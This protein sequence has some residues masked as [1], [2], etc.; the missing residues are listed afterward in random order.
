MLSSMSSVPPGASPE[1]DTG[2]FLRKINDPVA[3]DAK[4]PCADL[5]NGLHQAVG[6][7]EFIEDILKNVFRLR[8]IGDTLA[9][10]VA[11]TAALAANRFGEPLVLRSGHPVCIQCFIHSLL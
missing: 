10:E 11:K 9:D 5:L 7:D 2:F 8:F 3:G 6:F 1:R 4:H